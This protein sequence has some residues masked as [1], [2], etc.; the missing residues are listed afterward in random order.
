MFKLKTNDK[1]LDTDS[2]AS[3]SANQVRRQSSGLK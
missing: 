1:S 3:F 2:K